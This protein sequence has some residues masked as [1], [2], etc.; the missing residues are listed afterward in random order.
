[1]FLT[2]GT[3]GYRTKFPLG[4]FALRMIPLNICECMFSL[5]SD[6]QDVSENEVQV[7]SCDVCVL[8]TV[9]LACN[10]K[11][12]CFKFCLIIFLIVCDTYILF[13]TLP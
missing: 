1:M 3:T 12:L 2:F 9:Q 13:G 5:I 7:N 6:A 8:S 4:S 10:I 11:I